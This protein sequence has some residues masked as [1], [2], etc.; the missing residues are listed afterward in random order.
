MAET[1]NIHKAEYG[2]RK[3]YVPDL[4][5][6][7]SL[8]DANYLKLMKLLPQLEEANE[9][10]FGLSR[11]QHELG[12]IRIQVLERCKYTTML[13]LEQSAQCDFVE[14]TCMEVRLYHDASMAEVTSCQ[15][16]ENIQA[17]YVQANR[18]V[19]QKD[20]KALC[21]E[22][23]ADWLSYCLRFGYELESVSLGL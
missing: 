8:C 10:Y 21:N 20:E 1:E 5:A 7:M 16:I 6:L 18:A 11:G 12:L 17:K 19:F 3:H 9:R 22:F 14:P 23:L 15:G 2:V 4:S 13:R